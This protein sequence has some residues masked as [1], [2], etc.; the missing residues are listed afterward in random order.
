MFRQEAINYRKWKITRPLSLE[1][2]EI[3]HLRLPCILHWSF[4]HFVVLTKVTD[5]HFI[6]HDP[7]FGKN[8]L[9]KENFYNYF[10]GVA[11]E[12]WSEVKFEK[13]PNENNISF[14]E[15]LKHI[16]GIKG[17]L[18]KIF[19]LSALI[20]LIGLLIPIGTQLVMDHVIHDQRSFFAVNYLP[21]AVFVYFFPQCGEYVSRV[22]FAENG[23]F[24]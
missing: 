4:N 21:Q 8:K 12:I 13:K 20:E 15:T 2:D 3:K 18:I 24:D 11:L 7:A 1:L 22:D 16:S 6:I 10:T 5:K 9:N 19:A 23:L 17:A 14:Y